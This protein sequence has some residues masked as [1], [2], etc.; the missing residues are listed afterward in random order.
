MNNES[1]RIKYNLLKNWKNYTSFIGLILLVIISSILSPTFLLPLNIMNVA[2]QIAVPGV[3]AI[4]M[5]YVLLSGGIDLS[6]GSV[7]A[8]IGVLIALTIQTIGWPAAVILGLIAGII[9]GSL[10]G[11]FVVKFNVP[12]FIV[13]LAGLTIFRGVA[14]VVTKSAAIHIK[15]D[16]FTYLGSGMVSLAVVYTA[17]IIIGAIVIVRL[18][19]KLRS[20]PE[21]RTARNI[22]VTAVQVLG[23]GLLAY[24]TYSVGG[25]SIQIL[26]FLITLAIF[27]FILNKTVFGR[28]VYA[29]GGNIEAARLA[30]LKV[31][32]DLI[33]VYAIGAFTA[34]IGGIMTAARLASGTPQIGVGYELDAIAAVVIGGT[35]L[36]GG[37]GTMGGTVIGVL[38]IGVL[39]NLLSLL[40]MSSDVQQIFK[41]F[42]I[43]GAVLLD[44]KSRKKS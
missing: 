43:L 7:V 39:N 32:R 8:V 27:T 37:V 44:A 35:S 1:E 34:A 26:V 17:L 18:L 21:K 13:T 2:R 9:I 23:L 33:I 14:L 6:V 11:F 29:L 22:I 25:L 15:D 40:N 16:G 10:Y 31:N 30:G 20:N 19:K 38:L 24:L 42:I 5:T 3:I 41:G 4:G 28:E 36:V 12:P